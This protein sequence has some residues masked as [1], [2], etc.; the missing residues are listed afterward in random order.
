MTKRK[1]KTQNIQKPKDR[2]IGNVNIK[3]NVD[4]TCHEDSQRS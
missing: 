4:D 3:M 1:K 2:V